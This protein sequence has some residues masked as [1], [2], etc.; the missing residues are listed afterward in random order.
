MERT[1]QEKL[2]SASKAPAFALEDILTTNHRTA[3]ERTRRAQ[4]AYIGMNL[5]FMW[6]SISRN[7]VERKANQLACVDTAV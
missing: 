4:I 2:L 7:H 1:S 3:P 5:F 6:L